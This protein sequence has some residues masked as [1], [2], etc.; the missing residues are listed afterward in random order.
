MGQLKRVKR[1]RYSTTLFIRTNLGTFVPSEHATN[2]ALP[3][4]RSIPH[5]MQL[6]PAIPA[7]ATQAAP[8]P[9]NTSSTPP[10]RPCSSSNSN[11]ATVISS[12]SA[13]RRKA[14][15]SDGDRRGA[16]VGSETR[17][18]TVIFDPPPKAATNSPTCFRTTSRGLS[19]SI[20]TRYT[21]T[22]AATRPR[23]ERASHH[24]RQGEFACVEQMFWLLSLTR[25]SPCTTLR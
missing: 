22:P 4:G 6:L 23:T 21:P 13:C 12:R 9:G 25:T 18:P 24:R 15:S 16:L 8:S 20:C 11:P 17:A 2:S 5:A 14:S 19:G 3:Q 10:K 1:N 7:A